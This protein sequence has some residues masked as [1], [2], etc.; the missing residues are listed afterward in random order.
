MYCTKSETRDG[1]QILHNFRR[2]KELS[3]I[4]PDRVY[5]QKVIDIINEEPDDRSIHWFYERK[6]NVGKSALV[7]YLV[8]KR[9]A[10]FIDEG[11]KADL[12][13][14]IYKTDMDSKNIVLIDIPRANRNR[15][16]WKT[17]ES[18]KNGLICN[19][20]FETGYKAFEAPHVVVFSNFPPEVT[21][22]TISKDR[23]FIYE[24]QDDFTYV[25]KECVI[26][27]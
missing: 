2:P 22:S 13:N 14:L 15:V 5:Q 25:T 11:K 3:I 9:E 4:N 18:I 27:S 19:T 21:D 6:G 16:S 23:V 26:P 7:K 12:I 10:V 8:I 20:K 1:V 17:I 24:I